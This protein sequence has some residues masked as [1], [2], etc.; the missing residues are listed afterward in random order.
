MPRNG[1]RVASI[2]PTPAGD[3]DGD[4]VRFKLR[5][6]AKSEQTSCRMLQLEL[7]AAIGVCKL[8]AETRERAEAVV[9][10]LAQAEKAYGGLLARLTR[11]SLMLRR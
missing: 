8:D 6:I 9:A 5:S 10:A 1:I 3:I 4:E 2:D 7:T 11:Q